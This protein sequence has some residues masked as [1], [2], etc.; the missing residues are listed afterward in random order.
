[1]SLSGEP[2]TAE[3]SSATTQRANDSG[4]TEVNMAT[5][6]QGLQTTLAQLAK[7]SELQTEAIQ[8]LKED[9]LLCSGDEDTEDTP[10]LDDDRRDNA[11]DIAATLAHVLDSSDNNNTTSVKSP[12]S[13]SQS[14]LVESLTQ[15][16]TKSKVTSPAI[17]GKIAELID[18]MLIGG[19]SAETVKER[20][21]K[22]PPPENCKFLAVTMVNEEIWDLL[23]RKSRA[24]DLAFQRVQE[25]LL[26]GISA[27]TNLAGKL[28]KDVHDGKTPNTRDVLTHV[29]DSVAMLGNTNW[30]LN[31]KRR[32]LI[33]PE[34]NPPY[35]RLCKEDIAVST[36]LFGDDL[37]KH[38]KDMSEAK[39]AGQQMQKPYSNS[40]NR[41]GQLREHVS[42]WESLTSDSF[43]LDAIKHYHIEFEELA[44]VIGLLVSSLPGVQ[45]GR[46]HY[47]QL[48][49]DKSRAL[50]LCK[51]NYDGP[52][53]LSNDSRSE[54]EWW[55]NNI[56]S[57]FM[58][59]T[60]DK[61]DFTLTTDASKIGWG[62]SNP[63]TPRY[64]TTW[65]VQTV[66]THLSSQDSVE[67]LDLKSLTLKLLMLIAL[68]SA[69]RGQS[70]H[71]LDTAC[72]KV[73]ESSYEFSLPEHVKQSRPSF[74]TPSVILKAY[75]VN[76]ALCVYSHLTEYL[77]RTQSLRGAETKLFISFVKP[78][79][80][81]SRDTISRWIRTTMESAGIDIS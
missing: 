9:I 37:P 2:D 50:Q 35:T 79:K 54:L 14:A 32:E 58:P 22:H 8:N 67:K 11:L 7:N 46:L 66:L 53:T 6:L 40:S 69:Q 21:E 12:E 49:K 13:G 19:L 73:T 61:P 74:K 43:I 10:A 44:H 55:V 16:F 77:R 20:V 72:M 23:P 52:V 15:A 65:N 57:S 48:E 31:M 71:M 27:L 68:V 70:I 33:K 30:K 64:H 78:H 36:K 28:V 29:M 80:R 45:F 60:Q 42:A 39:K 62:A 4:P 1:M 41:A 59:I 56:T 47:R 34:L 25:P 5:V 17:E 63:P 75:P 18:N 38:L 3:L 81:V 26:Q 76:K 51:G 24:V